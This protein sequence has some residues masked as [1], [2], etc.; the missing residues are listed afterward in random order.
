M[1]LRDECYTVKELA[2]KLDVSE[3]TLYRWRKADKGPSWFKMN[4]GE[5][6]DVYYR[7]SEVLKWIRK[8]KSNGQ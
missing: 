1:N 5:K 3:K 6:A 8:L 4:Q 2:V 7:K